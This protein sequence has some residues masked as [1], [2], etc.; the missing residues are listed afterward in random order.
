MLLARRPCSRATAPAAAAASAVVVAASGDGSCPSCCPPSA[1]AGPLAAGG[2]SCGVAARKAYSC[3]TELAAAAACRQGRGSSWA[4]CRCT[5]C[6]AQQ[7]PPLH[8][9]PLALSRAMRSWRAA[10]CRLSSSAAAACLRF[11]P[12]T[13]ASSSRFSRSSSC[14]TTRWTLQGGSGQ[15]GAQDGEAAASVLD[16]QLA[17]WSPQQCLSSA[18]PHLHPPCSHRS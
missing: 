3:C 8:C 14:H 13:S 4:R 11:Q 12:A 6:P 7:Q 9:L 18:S 16:F 2:C 17:S 5:F 10:R 15:G 1:A